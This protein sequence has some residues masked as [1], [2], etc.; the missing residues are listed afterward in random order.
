MSMGS[1]DFVPTVDIVSVASAHLTA[2]S[3]AELNRQKQGRQAPILSAMI[4]GGVPNSS[5]KASSSESSMV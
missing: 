2:D 1:E 4:D 3:L 5:E